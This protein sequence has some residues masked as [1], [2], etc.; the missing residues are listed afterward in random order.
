[1][2]CER[3]FHRMPFDETLVSV[4][5]PTTSARRQFHD[6]TYACFAAQS[7][8]NKE[9][10]VLETGEERSSFWD[11]LARSDVR[12]RYRF[13]GPSCQ[14]S[15]GLKR[16]LAVHYSSGSVIAHFDDDDLY[17][18][19]YLEAMVA[20]LGRSGADAVTLS[21][22]HIFDELTGIA[23]FCD[24]Q[25]D[26][27]TVNSDGQAFGYGFSYVYLRSAWLRSPFPDC[28]LGEDYSFVKRLRY[29][30]SR[31]ELLRDDG[32]LCLHV[33][34]GSNTT[35]SFAQ[36]ISRLALLRT[37]VG[38][39]SEC[40]AM[41]SKTAAPGGDDLT[42]VPMK[43]CVHIRS[44]TGH[45]GAGLWRALLDLT[46]C[47]ELADEILDA[48]GKLAAEHTLLH[49]GQRLTYQWFASSGVSSPLP[50][51][52]ASARHALA[53]AC[54]DLW[55]GAD[56]S[57]ESISVAVSWRFRSCSRLSCEPCR[58][59][60]RG[61][62]AITGDGDGRGSRGS[63]ASSFPAVRPGAEDVERAALMLAA[64]AVPDD[65]WLGTSG[66]VPRGLLLS[67]AGLH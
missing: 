44:A 35:S 63:I 21:C 16:N 42:E 62:T 33:Q 24:S 29:F 46:T 28:D 49:L 13:F 32:G 19:L 11:A 2:S 34:H 27:P 18:P 41:L 43:G 22:W 64:L 12:V 26:M 20:G 25:N 60:S 45:I 17:A 51:W 4:V 67:A 61:P 40:R 56:W 65:G 58:L 30:G 53:F 50:G 36:R 8:Q 6:R 59:I 39:M 23:G 52:I 66:E 7:F 1:M 48:L 9:L 54:V 14:W 31:V 47:P 57:Q 10:V 55:G 3:A 38:A 15:V 37:H 5:C